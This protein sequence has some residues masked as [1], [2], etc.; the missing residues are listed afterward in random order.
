MKK[1]SIIV[2]GGYGLTNFGDDALLK[3]IH[4]DYL[5][6]Y[7]KKELAYSS[8]QVDYLKNEIQNYPTM[9]LKNSYSELTKVLIYGG[10]TQFYSF[11]SKIPLIKKI[12]TNLP[13]ILKPKKLRPKIERLFSKIC[14]KKSSGV[15]SD[16]SIIALGIG[17]GPFL[18]GSDPKIEKQT[19]LIFQAMDF[20]AVRDVYSYQ[21]CKEWGIKNYGLYA[22]LCFKMKHKQFLKHNAKTNAHRIG[23]I[24]RDWDKTKEGNSY[25]E[26]LLKVASNLQDKGKDVR[27]IVFAKEK[28]PNWL[29]RLKRSKIEPIIW[30]PDKNTI[31]HFFEELASFDLFI[32]SRYHGAIFS[33]L[34][35]KPFITIEVEQKLAMISDIFKLGSLNWSFPFQT[36][37][38]LNYFNQIDSN[39][40]QFSSNIKEATQQQ[41]KLA[42]KMKTDLDNTLDKIL[43]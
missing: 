4:N 29:K 12:I 26:N 3:S 42:D 15:C 32:T 31:D 9:P 5:N 38:L 2:R 1:Y 35:G 37:E 17:V 39:Y 30:N 28:D 22:D 10:G 18:E 23:I 11:K 24:V 27:F 20:V 13:L 43:K 41:I 14:Y 33:A 21:K 6:K 40:T 16:F 19:K 34:L 8:T 36:K 25:R 7:S